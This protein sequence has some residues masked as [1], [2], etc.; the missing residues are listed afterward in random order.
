MA[1]EQLTD[2]MVALMELI[3]KEGSTVC[4]GTC[5]QRKPNE[6]HCQRISF[7]LKMSASGAKRRLR[8]LTE[9]G[10]LNKERVEREDGKVMGKWTLNGKGLKYLT[11]HAR[12][13]DVVR[14]RAE[15]D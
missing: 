8:E 13:S 15:S 2:D 3:R 11:D 7:E 5:E 14:G 9:V 12:Q 10:Y 4:T 1:Q 6:L